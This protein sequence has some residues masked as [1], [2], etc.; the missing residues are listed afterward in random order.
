MSQVFSFCKYFNFQGKKNE[1]ENP[2]AQLQYM[3]FPCARRKLNPLR[4]YGA[5]GRTSSWILQVH[6]RNFTLFFK[7]FSFLQ[8][9]RKAIINP[10]T[11]PPPLPPVAHLQYMF[12]PCAKGILNPLRGY[13]VTSRTS[14]WILH[15]HIRN[16]ISF[17]RILIS[18]IFTKNQN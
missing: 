6:I 5:T 12:F 4:S 7:E 14:S 3:L 18:S 9:S 1:N 2:F 17:Q 15:V 16:L 8:F 11:P 13:G 10:N